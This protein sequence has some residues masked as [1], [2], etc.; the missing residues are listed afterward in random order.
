MRRLGSP[1]LRHS[2]NVTDDAAGLVATRLPRSRSHVVRDRHLCERRLC[3]RIC[4]AFREWR[5]QLRFRFSASL[6][7][8]TSNLCLAYFRISRR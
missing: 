4:R 5:H 2:R 7:C 8:S 3:V 6:R 1:R